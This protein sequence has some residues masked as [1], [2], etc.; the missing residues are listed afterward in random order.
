MNTSIWETIA[1]TPWWFF[2]V[3]Y[4]ALYLSYQMTK[5]Q[6]IR[7]KAWLVYNS[8]S[9][10]FIL[11]SLYAFLHLNLSIVGLGACFACVGLL[12]GW[13]HFHG[14]TINAEK[15]RFHLP[16]SWAV[17]LFCVAMVIGKYY[18]FGYQVFFDPKILLEA[19]YAPYILAF[20][21]L[22]AGLNVGRM[23]AVLRAYR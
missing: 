5:P 19:K 15:T 14:V 3:I 1:L 13:L 4:S 10:V 9:T 7:L 22:F 18:Y 21:G 17:M 20:S 8:I 12:L 11:V 6:T 2:L 23:I 16:G